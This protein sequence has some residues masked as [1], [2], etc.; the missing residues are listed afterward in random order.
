MQIGLFFGSFNPVH[1]GHLI[2]SNHILNE[3][4]LNKI[5][6]VVSP[7]N[8]FKINSD[9]LDENTR[10]SLVNVAVR[11]DGRLLASDIEFQLPRP[12]F[13]V[14]TLWFLKKNYSGHDFV[15]I[16]GSDNFRDLDKWKNYEDIRE[17]FKILIYL[18]P[19]FEVQNKFDADI[20]VLNAPILDISSTQIRKLIEEGKS[21]RYLVPEMVRKEIEEKEYYKK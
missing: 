16:M 6:F 8:P 7:L 10:L 20:Q 15:I 13:T 11:G 18:R 5:W 14:N 12:S 4:R 1:T 9:L 19:G 3:T 21:I 2:I 17:N